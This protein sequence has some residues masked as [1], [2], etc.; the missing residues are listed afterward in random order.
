LSVP[1]PSS[2]PPAAAVRFL[3]EDG[4]EEPADAR[5][6][7]CTLVND[8]ALYAAMV[9][10]FA[11]HGFGPGVAEFIALDTTGGAGCD[12]F[13]GIPRLLAAAR[14][15]YVVLCHQDV[16]L[17]EDGAEALLARLAE[18]DLLDPHWALA[19]N[20]G[21]VTDGGVADDGL[22]IRI[23]DPHGED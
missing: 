2:A 9:E 13:Q 5:F 12:A 15:Q 3:T 23:S 17:L 20:A 10:S 11:A 14:R 18:L 8:R 1:I 16:R 7:I 4:A 21:G 22:A 19:G 6:S